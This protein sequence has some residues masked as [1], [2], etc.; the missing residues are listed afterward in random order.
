M[1]R[2]LD[3]AWT[4]EMRLEIDFTFMMKPGVGEKEGISE[5]DLEK[6]GLQIQTI[7]KQLEEEK[8]Q[9]HLPFLSI[10]FDPLLAAQIKKYV[11]GTKTWAENFVVLGIGGSALGARPCKRPLPILTITCYPKP[12]GKA[13]PDSLLPTM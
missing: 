3:S 11:Q 5:E 6:L 13:T 8:E 7:H 1:K 12:C 10:P 9:G 4:Q 2:W